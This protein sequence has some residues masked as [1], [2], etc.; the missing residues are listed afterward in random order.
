MQSRSSARNSQQSGFTLVEL[1]VVVTLLAMF[2]ALSLPL[3]MNQGDSAERRTL[4]RLA[5]TVKQLYN[6]A[7]LTRDEH[8]LTFDLE[9]NSISAFRLV[10]SDGVVEKETYGK[11]A[12]LEPFHLRQVD[13][14]GQGSFRNGQVS[15]RV[16]PLGWM[17][18]TRIALQ[19][20][21]GEQ[22]FLE[23][24]PLTGAT[25]IDHGSQILQ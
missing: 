22:T 5:G 15:V 19:N 13:V 11:T 10:S 1:V 8:L 18:Q 6:E 2:S 20:E 12:S 23:F 14:A 21:K 16:F 17:E 7:T 9:N 25:K 24:S 4:R 3:L